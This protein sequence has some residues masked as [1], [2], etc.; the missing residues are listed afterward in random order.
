[1]L[2]GFSVCQIR[3]AVDKV[4]DAISCDKNNESHEGND[5]GYVTDSNYKLG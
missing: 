4:C 3:F 2:Q 1:M 5:H